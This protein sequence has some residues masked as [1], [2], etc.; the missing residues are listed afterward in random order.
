M[1]LHRGDVPS[2]TVS[3]MTSGPYF[4]ICRYKGSDNP[5]AFYLFDSSYDLPSELLKLCLRH[6][7]LGTKIRI[8]CKQLVFYTG[9]FT[10][11]YFYCP[12]HRLEVYSLI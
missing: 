10:D 11:F 6:S 4:A 2:M 7:A 8:D 5:C 9:H 3:M 1:A 12:K